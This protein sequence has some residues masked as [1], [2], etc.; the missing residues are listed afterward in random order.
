MASCSADLLAADVLAA[1]WARS[2]CHLKHKNYLALYS[3]Y[4]LKY[5]YHDHRIVQVVECCC[6][7]YQE[8]ALYSL[9]HFLM[10]IFT[11][12]FYACLSLAIA[13]TPFPRR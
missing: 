10:R 4:V 3:N 12:F 8:V 9:D 1:P 2:V 7:S 6:G 5:S 13:A 11:L